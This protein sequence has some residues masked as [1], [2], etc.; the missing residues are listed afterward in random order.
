MKDK[1]TRLL[2]VAKIV[3][4]FRWRRFRSAQHVAHMRALSY[5]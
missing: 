3:V 2:N 5:V 4:M 1:L